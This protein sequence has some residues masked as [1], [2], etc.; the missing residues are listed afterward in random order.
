MVNKYAEPWKDFAERRKKYG[1]PPGVPSE[2]AIEHY[3]RLILKSTNN[4]PGKALVLGATPQI[5]D[6]LQDINFEV[7]IIDINF[8]M[9]F[10]TTDMM[11]HKNPE[12]I[13]VRSNWITCPLKSNYYDIV[14]GDLVL[15]NIPKNLKDKFLRQI[16]RVL[17]KDGSWI[18]KL[19]IMNI[20]SKEEN[21]EDLIEPFKTL[22]V[23][24]S[25]PR[26]LIL[27]LS[28]IAWEKDTEDFNLEH[29]K[30][31]IF[32]YKTDTGFNFPNEKINK[33]I[34]DIWAEWKP[35]NKKWNVSTEKKTRESV[36]KYFT[37]QEQVILNDC[38]IKNINNIFPIWLC[39]VKN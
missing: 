10:A 37:I 27:C 4:K 25:N 38:Q 21:F 5:R 16:H 31:E 15:C 28:N 13:I 39:K 30:K 23:K 32:K 22:P 1:V 6:M 2:S 9:I 36:E 34:I 17:K 14:I 18:T 12:E 33:Y 29:I 35:L 24:K 3:K 19:F 8:E 11:R 20:D 26:E 7:T